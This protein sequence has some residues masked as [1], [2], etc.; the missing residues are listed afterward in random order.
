MLSRDSAV[1]LSLFKLR[2]AG[3]TLLLDDFGT[4][5]SNFSSLLRCHFDKIKL[6]KSLL[7]SDDEKGLDIISTLIRLFHSNGQT[8]VV[9]G[10]ETK[11]QLKMLLEADCDF[12]QGYIYSKPLPM[13]EYVDFVLKNNR[14]GDQ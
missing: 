9:E 10:V 12:I 1:Q 13:D 8:V 2:M 14:I 3:F 11:E 7:I 6:D 4:G 5:Y